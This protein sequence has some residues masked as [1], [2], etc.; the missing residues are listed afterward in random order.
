MMWRHLPIVLLLLAAGIRETRLA[1][2]VA[3]SLISFAVYTRYMRA[4]MLDV[5][6]QATDSKQKFR[7]LPLGSR[8]VQIAKTLGAEVADHVVMSDGGPAERPQAA[9]TEPPT[10][11]TMVLP[12]EANSSTIRIA[13]SM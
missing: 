7:G 6:N 12:P 13:L 10:L 9:P 1:V 8:A 11:T 5:I 3:L 4:S 2:L